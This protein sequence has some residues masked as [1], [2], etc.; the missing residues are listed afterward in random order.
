MEIGLFKFIEIGG[1]RKMVG[2]TGQVIITNS[3]IDS[4]LFDFKAKAQRKSSQRSELADLEFLPSKVIVG[5]AYHKVFVF[6]K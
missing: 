5:P 6:S 1:N 2:P 3:I 4:E